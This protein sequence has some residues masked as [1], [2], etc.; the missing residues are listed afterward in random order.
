[1]PIYANPRQCM[2]IHIGVCIRRVCRKDTLEIGRTHSPS[3]LTYTHTHTHIVARR[4]N[5]MILTNW[6]P[7]FDRFFLFVPVR[8]SNEGEQKINDTDVCARQCLR[9]PPAVVYT[10]YPIR[11]ICYII[12]VAALR[13]ICATYNMIGSYMHNIYAFYVDIRETV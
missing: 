11:G 13:P 5:G 4:I 8:G 3:P 9:A 7:P 12:C 6:I 1:M 2:Y 10:C